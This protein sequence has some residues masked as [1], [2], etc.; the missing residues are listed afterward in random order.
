VRAKFWNAI[1]SIIKKMVL[2]QT[3]VDWLM[4]P[5]GKKEAMWALLSKTFILP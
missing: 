4:V 3:I 5:A 1:G 2:D